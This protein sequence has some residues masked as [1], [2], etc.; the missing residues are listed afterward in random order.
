MKSGL[1]RKLLMGIANLFCWLLQRSYRYQI[2][3]AGHRADA[4]RLHPNG[5]FAIASW[6]QN[7][8]AGILSHAKQGLYLLVSRSFDGDVISSVAHHLGLGAVRGSSSRGGQEALDKLIDM[9]RDGARSAFTVDGPKGPAYQ[10]K[11]GIF[12]LA[13]ATGA[14]ILPLLAIADRY[15]TFS[16]SWDQFR[17]PKPFAR[18]AVIYAPPIQVS[19]EDYDANLESL[20]HQ[21]KHSLHELETLAAKQALC[22][23]RGTQNTEDMRPC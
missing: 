13:S 7:C 16:K 10:P 14:P 5:A 11:R 6:H 12:Q 20:S 9:T 1:K 8:F 3:N 15:W 21:L 22:P 23:V 19:A 4:E 18:V 2:I 17:V